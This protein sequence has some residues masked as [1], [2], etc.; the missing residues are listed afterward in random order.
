MVSVHQRRH[1]RGYHGRLYWPASLLVACLDA[2]AERASCDFVKL[3]P[4]HVAASIRTLI[5]TIRKETLRTWVR[6]LPPG[7]FPLCSGIAAG[8]GRRQ[9]GGHMTG[10]DIT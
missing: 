10:S 8:F 5:P 7:R 4:R 6:G 9:P 2:P 3:A 1:E